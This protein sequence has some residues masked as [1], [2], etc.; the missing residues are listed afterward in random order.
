MHGAHAIGW[1]S[2]S[3]KDL[4]GKVGANTATQM[5]GMKDA[6]DSGCRFF[7][8]GQSG[9]E[10]RLHAYTSSLGA[11]Q[12]RVVDLRIE[13][14]VVTRARSLVERGKAGALGLLTRVGAGADDN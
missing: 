13:P 2:Y 8:L 11:S 5:A 4:G 12:Q 9:D 1:R 7:D 10:S 6:A 3:L 14:S